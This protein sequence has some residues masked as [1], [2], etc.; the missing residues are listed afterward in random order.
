M[1]PVALSLVIVL[2]VV[3]LL[4]FSPRPLSTCGAGALPDGSCRPGLS[5]AP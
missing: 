4:V 2:F 5:M 3:A 1:L